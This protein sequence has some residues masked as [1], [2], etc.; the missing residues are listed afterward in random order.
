M[1]AAAASDLDN[2]HR[3]PSKLRKTILRLLHSRNPA[4]TRTRSLRKRAGLSA[5]PKF[6]SH[7]ALALG[8]SSA[9]FEREEEEEEEEG[10]EEGQQPQ[11]RT[12]L[13]RRPRK[14]MRRRSPPAVTATGTVDTVGAA[15]AVSLSAIS[16]SLPDTDEADVDVTTPRRRK[17]LRS[18]RAGNRATTTGNTSTLK[19]ASA[20]LLGKARSLFLPSWSDPDPRH[21]PDDY[22]FPYPKITFLVD[23]PPRLVCQICRDTVCDLDQDP[24][25]HHQH[26][27]T[28]T[29][30]HAHNQASI[31]VDDSLFLLLPCG[32]A[33]GSL[34]L[35]TWFSSRPL[36][37]PTCPF[38]RLDLRH[39]SCGHPVRPRPLLAGAAHLLPR[40]LPDGGR[41]P[42]FCPPCFRAELVA[43]AER[44]ARWEYGRAGRADRDAAEAL[45]RSRDVLEEVMVKDYYVEDFRFFLGAW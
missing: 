7:P 2:K 35:K 29:Y 11:R 10:G 19:A 9:T 27:H 12:R 32:H 37:P 31:A 6:A 5:A 38:C 26:T 23:R 8:D 3:Q 17:Y 45:V 28:H 1:P 30:N 13:Q 15:S 20:S 39:P 16:A 25:H 22:Y 18:R 21:D 33:A 41:V 36:A 34:C 42:R 40:T 43:A 24:R 4:R 14:M 44:R